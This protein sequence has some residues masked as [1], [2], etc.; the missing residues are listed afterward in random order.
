MRSCVLRFLRRSRDDDRGAVMVLFAFGFV[1]FVGMAALVLDMGR[2]YELRREV[3]NAADA[4][5]HAAALQLPDVAAAEA[6]ANEYWELNLPSSARNASFTITFPDG[7][8]SRVR[9]EA[10][11][12]IE[13][14]F[15]PVL[16]WSEAETHIAAEVATQ[17]QDVDVVVV[18]DTSG[19]MCADSHGLQVD[20]PA[21]TKKKKWHPFTEVKDAA[22]DFP[23]Y[24]LDRHRDWLGL[25]S[26]SDRA[27]RE[28]PLAQ[29]W[30][31]Y[32]EKVEGLEPSG[33][34]N[35]G[36]ALEV[37]HDT[38]M[39]GRPNDDNLDIIVLLS[40]GEANRYR[41]ISRG[42][43]TWHTCTG[44]CS[45]ANN[46]VLTEAQEAADDGIRI[47]TI[48]LGEDADD[49][50][51]QEV[52][53]IGGGEYVYA[54]TGDDLGDAFRTVARLARLQFVE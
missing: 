10:D 43:T 8:E 34:T 38:V 25:V 12:D 44:G 31:A 6:A 21:E 14:L 33:Y 4:A 35:I 13:M 3:Q 39:Q 26:F 37:G 50:L 32:E 40:D 18:L 36:E 28:M 27:D 45:Q 41:T 20:C 49:D 7:G 16:G 23:N 53:D 9:V 11:A 22:L 15:A 30:P 46:F 51:M 17:G 1:A 19:S 42:R 47:F 54:P 29:G 48:G 2:Y 52:A 5:A 24:F